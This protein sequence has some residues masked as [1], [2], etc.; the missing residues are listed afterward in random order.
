MTLLTLMRRSLCDW[1]APPAD[2]SSLPASNS[3]LPHLEGYFPRSP[4]YNGRVVGT[5][6]GQPGFGSALDSVGR[7]GEESSPVLPGGSLTS[8]PTWSNSFG[9]SAM[10]AC[11]VH[12]NVGHSLSACR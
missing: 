7:L 1:L 11:F 10:S 2:W 3:A 8:K 5:V 6:A 9:C 12:G 4:P